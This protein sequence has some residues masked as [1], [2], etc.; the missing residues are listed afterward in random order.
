ML[1]TTDRIIKHKG[2]T[3]MGYIPYKEDLDMKHFNRDTVK[4]AYTLLESVNKLL[5]NDHDI[6][7]WIHDSMVW[8][9][10]YPIAAPPTDLI[11]FKGFLIINAIRVEWSVAVSQYELIRFASGDTF[12]TRSVIHKIMNQLV[13]VL[14]KDNRNG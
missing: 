2:E 3:I 11:Y 8:K 9:H 5:V 14:V 4:I 6:K 7:I 1:N 13:S 10:N 12:I